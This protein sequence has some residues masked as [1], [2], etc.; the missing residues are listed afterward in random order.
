MKISRQEQLWYL[1]ILTAATLTAQYALQG[2]LAL[3]GNPADIAPWILTA[4]SA[5]WSL[6][7]LI[8]A[9]VL[10][11]LF[12]TR[13]SSR[14]D[15]IVLAVLEFLLIILITCTLGPALGTIGAG[16]SIREMMSATMYWL[17]YA[18]IASYAPLMLAAAG[19]AYKIQPA[20][21]TNIPVSRTKQSVPD[22][23]LEN[24]RIARQTKAE[25]RRARLAMLVNLY[26]NNP[27]ASPNTVAAIL[28]VS[29]STLYA[30]L[31]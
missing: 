25:K 21:T 29:K 26:K 19:L 2:W 13:A 30:Y 14:T 18:S 27:E 1:I 17:W 5:L 20:G 4:D 28:G 6:R 11:Y 9:W 22:R 15:S 3:G 8:E 24:L 23:M 31:N 10:V 12:S 7:A 16:K